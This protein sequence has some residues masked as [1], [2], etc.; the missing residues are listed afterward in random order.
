MCKHTKNLPIRGMLDFQDSGG[1]DKGKG[2]N[3]GG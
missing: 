3:S 1:F 2:K